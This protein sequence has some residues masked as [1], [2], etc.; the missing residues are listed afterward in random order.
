MRVRAAHVS[1]TEYRRRAMLTTI[2]VNGSE[3]LRSLTGLS[4]VTQLATPA[5]PLPPALAAMIEP[6]GT[7]DQ[8]E[9]EQISL[10]V[11]PPLADEIAAFVDE[12]SGGLGMP[13]LFSAQIGDLVVL[14]RDVLAEVYLPAGAVGRLVGRRGDLGKLLLLEGRGERFPVHEHAYISDRCT[15]RRR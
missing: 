9:R 13:L 2:T 4:R 6:L 12:L 15:T 11:E 8:A 10:E 7:A 3:G 1:P 5:K 14:V